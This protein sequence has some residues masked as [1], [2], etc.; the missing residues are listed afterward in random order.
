[1]GVKMSYRSCRNA[2]VLSLVVVLTYVGCEPET[3]SRRNIEDGFMTSPVSDQENAHYSE[4]GSMAGSMG[5]TSGNPQKASLT[6]EE[7][8]MEDTACASYSTEARRVEVEVPVEVE[9]EV[10]E[11][12]PVAIYL[13]LDQSSSMNEAS[14]TGTKWQVAVN[15]INA[16]VNDP[17]SSNI[18]IALQYFPSLFG[19]CATGAGYNTPEVPLC[20]LP[21][22]AGTI[23]TSLLFHMPGIGGAYTPIEG[24]LRGV[25]QFCTQFKKDSGRNLENED[26]V[27]VLITDGKPTEC[28]QEADVLIGI[29]VD[30]QKQYGVRTYTI[31][32]T[33]A[34][35]G[36]LDQIAQAGNGDCTLAPSDTSW[37][38]NVSNGGTSLIDTLNLI[39]GSVT[40]LQTRTE[41]VTEYRTE[42]LDC[43]WNIPDP[44]EG[45]IFDKDKVNVQFSPTGDTTHQRIF[46]RVDSKSQCNG[47]ATSWYYDDFHSPSS[48]IACPTT[49][50]KI[51]Q[52]D[53]GRINI[54]VGCRTQVY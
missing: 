28:C 1:M 25:T 54:L 37:A 49:C 22:N 42:A 27:A 40:K 7:A 9:V 18:D 2:R 3:T 17:A 19:D 41:I 51:K 39:R 5:G 21:D 46:P 36:L 8:S 38:C 13:I 44:P 15:A 30:A 6:D 31:G 16:F 34:D 20:R 52:T 4:D 11:A 50:D 48:I 45:E 32:M 53:A 14:N 43:I 35:F 26:C 12:R 23:S 10:T 33:G 24:A 29:A 47:S